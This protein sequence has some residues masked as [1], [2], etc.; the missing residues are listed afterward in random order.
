[1]R[2]GAAE[3]GGAKAGDDSIKTV[4]KKGVYRFYGESLTVIKGSAEAITHMKK[5]RE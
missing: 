2:T 1:L 5:I 4:D 3:K